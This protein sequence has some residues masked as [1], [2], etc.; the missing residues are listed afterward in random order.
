[1]TRSLTTALAALALLGCHK[2]APAPQAA[3]VPPVQ[4][5]A[6]LADP[7]AGS[8]A[9]LS[10]D[11]DELAPPRRHAPAP[12]EKPLD[13]CPGDGDPLVQARSFYD[14]EKFELALACSARA[15]ADASDSPDAH[16]ERAADLVALGRYDE[17]QLAFARALALD[18]D[19]L[20]A[21]LGA[22]DLYVTRLPG[23]RDNDELALVYAER[24]LKLARKGKQ[25]ELVGSFALESAMAQNDLGRPREALERAEEALKHGAPE[26]DAIYEKA[27]A[28]YELCRFSDA[29]ALFVRLA[30]VKEKEAFARY[31]LG[32]IAER[33]GDAATASKEMAAAREIDADDFPAEVPVT[34]AG[35]AEMVHRQ[36]AA[37]PA[38]MQKD[39]TTL[40]VQIEDL[41]DLDDLTAND[42]PLSPAILGLFRGPSLDEKCDAREP[43]PCRS[44]VLYR[45]NLA[46]VTR[47]TADLEDQVRVT[48]LHE[49]GHLR[50]EDDMELAA[51]GLE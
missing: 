10:K 17:A 45:K 12:P 7:H 44:I 3:P 43:G 27:S 29:K 21:L 13:L 6:N 35:F 40:P 34:A 31:H 19:H 16:A 28:L 25:G 20:D 1:M 46:R 42:P 51:R 4:V 47:D 2:P 30:K 38:D 23:S 37:L 8:R 5:Q 33:A 48:L 9:N 26:D 22:S 39:L 11:K 49:I 41:P 18:P 15:C 14:H 32:L 50:G 36:V 24:G